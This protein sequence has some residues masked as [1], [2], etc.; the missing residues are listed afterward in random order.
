MVEYPARTSFE[1]VDG[2]RDLNAPCD[3][4]WKTGEEEEKGKSQNSCGKEKT[5][6]PLQARNLNIHHGSIARTNN[7]CRLSPTLVVWSKC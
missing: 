2:R 4:F 6:W 5:L 7:V 3:Q 1:A